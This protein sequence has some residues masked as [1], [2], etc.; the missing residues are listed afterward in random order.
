MPITKT[1]GPN[2]D[3]P[4]AQESAEK[5]D[6]QASQH[7]KD[8]AEGRSNQEQRQVAKRATQRLTWES[9]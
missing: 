5:H 8:K 4:S 6:P 7:A 2:P 1:G 9:R 3:A